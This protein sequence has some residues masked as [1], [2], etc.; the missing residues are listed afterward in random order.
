MSLDLHWLRFE[1]LRWLMLLLMVFGLGLGLNATLSTVGE[2]LTMRA[3]GFGRRRR[4]G[5][6]ADLEEQGEAQGAGQRG[7]TDIGR[8]RRFWPIAAGGVLALLTWDL[9]ISTLFFVLGIGLSYVVE[10]RRKLGQLRRLTRQA[11][12]LVVKFRSMYSIENSIF[13]TLEQAARELPPGVVRKAV[14]ACVLRNLSGRQSTSDSLAPLQALESPHL[15]R[16]TSVLARAESASGETFNAVLV[17]LE[18]DVA[19]QLQIERE[20]GVELA[21]LKGTAR[22]LQSVALAATIW[23]A[24]APA[25]REYFLASFQQKGLF[26]VL[27][28]IIAVGSIYLEKEIFAIEKGEV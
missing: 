16:F 4:L 19:R 24:V 8:L 6:L 3:K 13:G 22:V 9:P 17:E 18:T 2:G 14:E 20:A 10:D 23:A 25:W 28:L 11:E 15:R 5:L 7:R 26:I 12:I 21:A 1:H 27:A